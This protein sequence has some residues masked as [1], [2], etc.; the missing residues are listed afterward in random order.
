MKIEVTLE[1]I[2]WFC[3]GVVAFIFGDVW[4]GVSGVFVLIR[5]DAGGRVGVRGSQ[6]CLIEEV[7][8]LCPFSVMGRGW[9]ARTS[10]RGEGVPCR[11]V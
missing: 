2:N 9:Q 10:G 11:V 5:I 6:V 7:K 1:R 4:V 8:Y 3:E